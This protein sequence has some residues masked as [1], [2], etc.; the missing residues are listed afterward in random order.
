[1]MRSGFFQDVGNGDGDGD[2]MTIDM[3]VMAI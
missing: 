3:A 2:D 1:M